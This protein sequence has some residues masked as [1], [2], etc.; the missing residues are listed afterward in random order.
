M[1]ALIQKELRENLKLAVLGLGILTLILAL[2]AQKY[3]TILKNLGGISESQ[4]VYLPWQPLV[5]SDIL[6]GFFCA[7]FGAVL[8]WF[9]IHNESHRDLWAFLIHRFMSWRRVCR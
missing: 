5:S 8:G 3:S 9:Q 2:N 1:K 4:Q 7:I 6:I